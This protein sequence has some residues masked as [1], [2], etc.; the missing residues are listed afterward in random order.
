MA[1]EW[2]S[3]DDYLPE[4]G[5]CVIAFD[6]ELSRESAKGFFYGAD[7]NVGEFWGGQWRVAG[8]PA[9]VTHWMPFPQSPKG[10]ANGR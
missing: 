3:V 10:G 2:I 8:G 9:N 4:I 5:K 7:H 1:G 6:P